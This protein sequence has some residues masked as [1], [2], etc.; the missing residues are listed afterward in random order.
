MLEAL[1]TLAITSLF[2]LGSYAYSIAVPKPP[3]IVSP[4]PLYQE[5]PITTPTPPPASKPTTTPT[6]TPPSPPPTD[7]STATPTQIPT[8]TPTLTPQ[9]SLES[10]DLESLFDHFAG[11]FSVDENLL[12]R[13]AS[14]ESG[15]NS[16]AEN[17]DYQGMFQFAASSWMTTR[18]AMG[19]DINTDLRKNTEEAIKTA[20][21]M[22]AHNG[23]GAWPSCSK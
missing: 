19:A 17:G 21:F 4:L 23:A 7:G 2:S 14:C 1:S 11:E 20:A 18:L 10:G 22:I 5:I 12:K 15:F 16:N 6:P 8:V 13:I 3:P 9:P